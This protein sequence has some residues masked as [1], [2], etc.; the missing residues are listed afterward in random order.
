MLIINLTGRQLRASYP[1]PDQLTMHVHTVTC[2]GLEV[3]DQPWPMAGVEVSCVMER[4]VKYW[5]TMC[6]VHIR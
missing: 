5:S 6:R 4:M 1:R 2:T 3:F